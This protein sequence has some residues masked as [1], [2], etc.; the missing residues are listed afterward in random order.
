MAL[1]HSCRGVAYCNIS[2]VVSA[3][4]PDALSYVAASV[5]LSH[6]EKSSTQ[7]PAL[8]M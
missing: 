4:K 1:Q 3:V 7:T 6:L 2:T 5:D 8:S